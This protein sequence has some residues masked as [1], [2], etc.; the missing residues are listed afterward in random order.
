MNTATQTLDGHID[1]ALS[2]YNA[3]ETIEKAIRSLLV[4]TYMDL[5]VYVV[6]DG[7]TDGTFEVLQR[8]L[9]EDKRLHVIRLE[10]NCGTYSAKNLVLK[11]FCK[12]EYF[13]HQDADDFSWENRLSSQVKYLECHPD[14]GACGTGIDEFYK[15]ESDAPIIPSAFEAKFNT[16]DGF[17]HRKNLYDPLIPQGACFAYNVEESSRVRTAMNG[18]VLCR[19]KVLRKL[20][21]FDGRTQMA[22]D[23][24]LLFRLMTQHALGNLQ[25][26]LYSRL[27]HSGSMTRSEEFGF[28]SEKRNKY[29]AHVRER[30]SK[31]KHLNDAGKYDELISAVT[32]TMHVTDCPYR[33]YHGGEKV[34][35][36]LESEN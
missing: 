15:T 24:E 31:L 12:G 17:F 6:D 21:G 7:S 14:V 34:P 22:G 10:K 27:F 28:G 9:P 11:H 4:Q 2:A 32:E 20:G 36:G 19:V 29:A 18:S 16:E 35:V 13:A 1:V 8:L 25:E 30:L 33:I 23:S 5:D 26:V 3:E